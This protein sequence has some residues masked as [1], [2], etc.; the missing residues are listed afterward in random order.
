[1][2]LH[3]CQEG[4]LA[5]DIYMFGVTC[6]SKLPPIKECKHTQPDVKRMQRLAL[7]HHLVVQQL[8]TKAGL[9]DNY[10][11]STELNTH[12]SSSQ[13]SSMSMLPASLA[14]S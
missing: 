6:M 8:G 9:Q 1:M 5:S 14:V 2:H 10:T 3:V 13:S 12:Q 7:G 11:F 4:Q